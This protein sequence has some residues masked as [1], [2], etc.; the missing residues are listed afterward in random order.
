MELPPSLEPTD[1]GGGTPAVHS[2][3]KRSGEE[4]APRAAAGLNGERRADG[5]CMP[6]V[7]EVG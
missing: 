2:V 6:N 5:D 3:S 4:L 7:V 1:T